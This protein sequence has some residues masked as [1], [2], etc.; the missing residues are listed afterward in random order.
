MRY[1]SLALLAMVCSV[2]LARED[3]AEMCTGDLSCD[4]GYCCSSHVLDQ[5]DWP[6]VI[7]YKEL[8]QGSMEE[9]AK[10][11]ADQ[12]SHVSLD[13]LKSGV[14]MESI[15]EGGVAEKEKMTASSTANGDSN[16]SPADN[17]HFP[18]SDS[19]SP[20]PEGALLAEDVSG[21]SS[22]ANSKE[23]TETP[24]AKNDARKLTASVAGA[25][26]G[27]FIWFF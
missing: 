2:V 11:L 23:T 10:Q 3:T 21:N 13:E 4:E 7:S 12:G 24:V 15:L 27:A 18:S 8:G 9:L 20:E 6:R 25:V 1:Q 22:K 5:Q 26:L 17:V 16:A 19:S 14:T